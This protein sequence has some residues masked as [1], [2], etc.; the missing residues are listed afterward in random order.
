MFFRYRNSKTGPFE[1]WILANKD[2]LLAGSADYYGT[3]VSDSTEFYE[4]KYVVSLG[5]TVEITTADIPSVHNGYLRKAIYGYS[6]L[7]LLSGWW[8]LPFGPLFTISAVWHNFS[9]SKKRTIGS[10]LQYLETGWEAPYDVS[11]SA[12]RRRILSITAR[13]AA[14]IVRR[15]QEGNFAADCGVR[16]SPGDW[17]GRE[18]SIQ[19]DFPVTDGHDWVDQEAGMLVMIDKRHEPDLARSEIDFADGRFV[20]HIPGRV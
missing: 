13:A 15:R 14:E 10:Y 1:A 19:F 8:G 6:A 12:H 9:N 17:A 7:T 16:I 3:E 2:D 20:A 5:I 4:L 11:I 18:V